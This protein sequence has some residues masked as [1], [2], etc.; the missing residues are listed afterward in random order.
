MQLPN[1]KTPIG[2]CTTFYQN[3]TK[4]TN[5]ASNAKSTD[6]IRIILAVLAAFITCVPKI[7]FSV[8]YQI[9]HIRISTDSRQTTDIKTCSG[10]DIRNIKG[11]SAVWR[12]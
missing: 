5:A 11:A 8:N 3:L 1:Y 2:N 9:I 6:I 12:T 4:R 10:Y 7:K